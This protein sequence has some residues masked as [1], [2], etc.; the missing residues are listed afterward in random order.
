MT[1]GN[2]FERNPSNEKKKLWKC[3]KQKSIYGRKTAE[4]W[5]RRNNKEKQQNNKSA[6]NTMVATD[7]RKMA[8]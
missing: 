7:I 2:I 4:T 6:E 8:Y 1:F 3:G 5:K